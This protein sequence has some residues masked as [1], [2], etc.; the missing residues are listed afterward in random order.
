MILELVLRRA[1]FE[2][3]GDLIQRL[4]QAL[5]VRV[6]A[7]GESLHVEELFHIRD[8]NHWLAPIEITLHNAWV[9]REGRLAPHAFT[10]K[11]RQDL[12]RREWNTMTPR[13]RGYHGH[14]HDVFACV[15]PFMHSVDSK[16]PILVLPVARANRVLAKCPG[17]LVQEEAMSP[18]RQ[19]ELL[20]WADVL[21]REEYGLPHA[22]AALRGMVQSPQPAIVCPAPWLEQDEAAPVDVLRDTGNEMFAH[23]PDTSW[24]LLATF[25]RGH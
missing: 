4:R 8:F 2:V 3:V 5:A 12:T 6:E 11:L 10:F 25:H 21:E 23:L 19:R 14:D 24:N 18:E 20:Q 22:A 1:P 15:K 13:D 16:K 7:K 9:S 17:V